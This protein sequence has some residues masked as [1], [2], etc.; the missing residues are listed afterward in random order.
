[1]DIPEI[2]SS[3]LVLDDARRLTG[4]SMLWGKTGAIL[5]VLIEQ[6]DMD[7][8]LKC[9]HRQLANL[10]QQIG[11]QDREF[12][13]R[14]YEN[15]FNLLLEAPIDALYSAV[16]VLETNWYFCCC[17][18]LAIDVDD[19]E[20]LVQEIRNLIKDECNPALLGLQLAAAE[21]E[22]DFLVDDDDVSIGHGEGS[23][24]WPVEQIPALD[25]IPWSE[26]H[27]VPVAMITGTNGKSTSV[28]LLD[29]IAK[30]A[31]QI[32]G[33]TSTDFVRVGNEVL[34]HGDYSGPGGARLLLRDKR[35]QVAFLEVARGG[36]LRRGLPL[37]RARAALVTNIASDHLGQYG[38]N[39]LEA[40]TEVKFAV[41]RTLAEDGVL[42][43]NADDESCRAYIERVEQAS[44]CW[45]SL[46][47][48]HPVIKGQVDSAGRCCYIEQD[49][50]FY[51]DGQQAHN[52]C[53]VGQIPMTIGGAALHN[54]QNALGA[55]GISMALGYTVEQIRMGLTKFHSDEH[56]NPGR[57]NTFKLK[58]GAT[59]IVDFA[60]N[61]HSIEAVANT[62]QR[63]P[64]SNRWVLFGSAGDRSDGD[65]DA[66]AKGICA[67]NPDQVVIVEIEKYLRGRK[68]GEVSEVMKNACLDA[69]LDLGRMRFAESPLEGVKLAIPELQAD[70]LGLFLVLAERDEIIRYIE[71]H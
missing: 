9:W 54:V 59:I 43:V 55:V 70:D 60:H 50:I 65:M 46:D 42:V 3:K 33:V 20:A 1:M 34:D 57:M 64:A 58:N 71:E 5:D 49:N 32:S 19:E 16:F 66:I 52:I 12:M 25:K 47:V 26:V 67:I 44:L 2:N 15:G 6:L 45:F 7:V 61:A 36:I 38:V 40:L 37:R 28:R 17:E 51:F 41:R 27:D 24:C 63:M 30:S 31:S 8:V 23:I 62:V 22:V 53:E 69:G 39:T 18:L 11:W 10:L 14:R 48:D 29:G 4:P 13:H 56:D 68:P 35:L 21:H